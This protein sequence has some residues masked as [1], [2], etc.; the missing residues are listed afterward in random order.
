MKL[1]QSNIQLKLEQAGAELG[2]TQVK[3]DDV[4][5]V[6]VLVKTL[7]EVVFQRLFRVGGWVGGRSNKTT[8]IL[9]ST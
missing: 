3:L 7:V 1:C 8:S 4:V 2:Q 6:E 9:I 5:V